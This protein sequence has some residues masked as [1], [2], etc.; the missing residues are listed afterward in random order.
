MKPILARLLLL[1]AVAVLPRLA[2]ASVEAPDHVL[3]GSATV[4]G[5][6]APLGSVIELRSALDNAVLV[7]YTLGRDPRLGGQY[8]LR[9][10]MDSVDPRLPGRSRPGEAIRIYIGPQLAAETVVGAEG[11][12]RRLDID[13]RNLGAG[14]A[15]SIADAEAPEGNAGSSL[16]TFNL[17]MTTTAPVPVN[18]EWTTQPG[19]ASGGL[20]CGIAGV[21]YVTETSTAVI[22]AGSQSTTL[23]VLLCGDTVSEVDESFTVALSAIQNGVLADTSAI[24]TIR[25]DDDLPSLGMSDLRIAEPLSGS[26]AARFVAVLSRASSAPVS[27]NYVTQNVSAQG[28]TD[29]VTGNGTLT[30]PAGQTQGEIVVPVLAD[31]NTESDEVFRLALSA[32]VNVT[33]SRTQVQAIIVDTTYNPA[34]VPEGDVIG[35][36]GGITGLAQPSDIVLS[37][38]GLHA[39]VSSESL[40]AVLAL[41]RDPVSGDLSLIAQYSA[42]SPGFAGVKLDGAKDIALSPDGTHLYVAARNDNAISVFARD[43]GT[44]TLTLVENRIDGQSG[45]SGAPIILGLQGVVAIHVSHDGRSLYAAGSTAGAIAVFDRDGATGGLT[46]VEAE[47]NNVNDSQDAGPTVVAMTQP[48]SIVSSHDGAQVYVAARSGNA[49][50]VFNRDNDGSSAQLGEL[51]Y[52]ASYQDALQ[53]VEGVAGAS[54][55]A[56]SADDRHVYAL[57]EGDNAVVLFDRQASGA[58]TWRAQW[59]KSAPAVPGLGGPQAI[60]VSPD[61]KEV[62]VAGFAD[63]SLTVFTRNGGTGPQAG[64]LTLRQ[65]VFDDE[66]EVHNMAGPAA[67]AAS[68]DD[69]HLYVA[70]NLDNAVMIFRRL[71]W[72]AMFEDGFEAVA[73]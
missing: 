14:P 20:A 43:A 62:F 25:D 28:G 10:P 73:P 29:Y 11:V 48:W 23:D 2:A 49:V 1:A 71:S 60:V 64:L 37:P 36:P 59:R 50:L 63:D 41:Q 58:L 44:G 4:F 18:I 27:I 69:R 56:I 9:I 38:D 30:I 54:G 13:P 68:S 24:A 72:D 31:A 65:T 15:V 53:G 12:A 52:A 8:S 16:L 46:F 6:P 32:P 21:D 34:I 33:L 55:L 39:Y 47:L 17:T 61:G 45:G 26:V 51:S 67:L 42:Q 57:G 35:G 22:A 66:G 7:R 5:N 3:Y 40:D 19:S 70:A